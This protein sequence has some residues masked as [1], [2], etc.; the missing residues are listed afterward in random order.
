MAVDGNGRRI[1]LA[2]VLCCFQHMEL[3]A[4]MKSCHITCATGQR[5]MYQFFLE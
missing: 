1:L 5:D 3:A 4:Q 2:I